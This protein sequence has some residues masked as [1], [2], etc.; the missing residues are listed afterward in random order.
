MDEKLK[1]KN[2]KLKTELILY[3][4]A[5]YSQIRDFFFATLCRYNNK[6]Q[7]ILIDN[8]RLKTRHER[9]ENPHIGN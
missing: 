7:K 1:Q 8:R 4:D 6:E 9:N 3:L 2:I 5:L